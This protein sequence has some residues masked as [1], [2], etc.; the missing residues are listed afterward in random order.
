MYVGM[1]KAYGKILRRWNKFKSSIYHNVC[2]SI[3]WKWKQEEASAE[4]VCFGAVT[5]LIW[6]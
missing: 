5:A 2:I 6:K 4:L 1:G 3:R